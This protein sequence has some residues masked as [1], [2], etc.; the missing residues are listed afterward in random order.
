MPMI[1]L[2]HAW[3]VRWPVTAVV[4][5]VAISLLVFGVLMSPWWIRNARLFHEFVPLTTAGPAVLISIYGEPPGESRICDLANQKHAEHWGDG[6][7]SM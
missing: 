7:S 1:L 5:S 3:R 6:L 2:L 4:R